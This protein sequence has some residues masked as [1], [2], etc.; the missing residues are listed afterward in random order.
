MAQR[1][2]QLE[3]DWFEFPNPE[4]ASS[5]PNGLLAIGGDLSVR[6]LVT[7]Y[8]SGIFPWFGEE[9]PILWWSPNPRGILELDELK[10][11]KVLLSLSDEISL[12]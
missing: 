1:I 12:Q 3:K 6:R 7:A 9:E 8:R 4:L 11:S 2:F 10:I 5:S